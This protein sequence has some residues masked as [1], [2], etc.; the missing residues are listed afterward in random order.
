[1]CTYMYINTIYI[2]TLIYVY[3]ILY[4]KHI[5]TMVFSS[6]FARLC[7]DC[8]RWRDALNQSPMPW[9]GRCRRQQVIYTHHYHNNGTII[10]EY[11][12]MCVYIYI[13]LYNTIMIYIYI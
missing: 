9:D 13:T 12:M 8:R 4:I 5:R 7:R 1:M 3:I 6:N 10:M 11:I 2:Y